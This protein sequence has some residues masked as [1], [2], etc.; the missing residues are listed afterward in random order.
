MGK[1]AVLQ[2]LRR[3]VGRELSF[4]ELEDWILSHL[5][6]AIDSGDAEY[7][8]LVDEID[9]LLM[10]LGDNAITEVDFFREICSIVDSAA[11]I[12]ISFSPQLVS[13][14]EKLDQNVGSLTLPEQDS[15]CLSF[16]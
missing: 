1:E 13:R 8:D 14:F 10:K 16:E 6:S 2:Q 4:D 3:Y 7:S 12:N 15:M 5:Q 9:V 11:T